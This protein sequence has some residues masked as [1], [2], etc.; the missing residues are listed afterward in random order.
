MAAYAA[1][2]A[3]RV[4]VRYGGRLRA[5]PTTTS[6]MIQFMPTVRA[7]SVPT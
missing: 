5:I 3:V 7:N 1:D 4:T 2:D 6:S